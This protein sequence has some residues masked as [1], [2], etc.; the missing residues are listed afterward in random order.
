V[1]DPLAAA[2]DLS[3]KQKA[4]QPILARYHEY[5]KNPPVQWKFMPTTAAYSP[6]FAETYPEIANIFD[7]LHML[8]DTISDILT[9]PQITE[10][11]AKR[12]EVYRVLDSYYLASADATNPMI[13]RTRKAHPKRHEH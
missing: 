10:W 8:H 3:A 7:N 1:Y 12:A 13:R 2:P 4:V 5:L 11:D 6:K 9:S